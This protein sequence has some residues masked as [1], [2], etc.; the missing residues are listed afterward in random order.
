MGL[1]LEEAHGHNRPLGETW[2][3]EL[4][5]ELEAASDLGPHG[6]DHSGKPEW[7]RERCLM[8]CT[9]CCG[10]KGRKQDCSTT[11]QQTYKM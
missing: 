8:A 6:E 11:V 9:Y 7:G 4:E 2:E 10:K 5:K 3:L 1:E